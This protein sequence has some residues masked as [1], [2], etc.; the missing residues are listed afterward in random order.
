MLN[1]AA[2]LSP[3]PRQCRVCLRFYQ[4]TGTRGRS[5]S[6]RGGTCGKQCAEAWRDIRWWLSE[7]E[8]TRH[9]IAVAKTVLG[10]DESYPTSQVEFAERCIAGAPKR[11]YKRADCPRLGTKARVLWDWVMA[12]REEVRL[13]G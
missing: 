7:D 3:D 13:A 5:P 2:L 12:K 6:D 11:K 10:S 9:Q 4:H 8:F 1:T